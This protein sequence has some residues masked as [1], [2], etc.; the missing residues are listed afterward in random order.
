MKQMQ[1]SKLFIP[2]H[3]H[4][5]SNFL[6]PV[7]ASSGDVMVS[8]STPSAA[9]YESLN[10]WGF[11]HPSIILPT[12]YFNGGLHGGPPAFIECRQEQ[13][14]IQHTHPQSDQDSNRVRFCHQQKPRSHCVASITSAAV[15]VRATK[16]QQVKMKSIRG[17]FQKQPLI[18]LR[19]FLIMDK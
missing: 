3:P 19:G 6:V 8:L 15:V 9:M 10:Y 17:H 12:V 14:I 5:P 18:S 2:S 4:I 7:T 11:I 16:L 1:T 13:S